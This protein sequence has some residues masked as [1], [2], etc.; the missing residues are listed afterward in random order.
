MSIGSVR[1][2][3][4]SVPDGEKPVIV[5]SDS[6]MKEIECTVTGRV[7]LVLYRDFTQRR[8]R[9]LGLSGTVENMSDGSVKVIAQGSEERLKKLV[10][11][12]R[13][14]SLL[15]RVDD[16]VMAWRQPRVRFTDFVIRYPS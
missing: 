6:A 2:K 9:A 1:K 5:R 7:Q 4:R 3:K 11:E 15:S 8:A 12:L 14:G 13:K 16:V 10:A